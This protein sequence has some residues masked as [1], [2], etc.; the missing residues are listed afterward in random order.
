VRY[1]ALSVRNRSFV[2]LRSILDVFEIH[3]LQL[4][5]LRFT[6]S[7]RLHFQLLRSLPLIF[8]EILSVFSLDVERNCCTVASFFVLEESYTDSIFK[9]KLNVIP[10]YL[11]VCNFGGCLMPKFIFQISSSFGHHGVNLSLSFLHL[12]CS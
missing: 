1:V 10:N 2:P 5:L 9:T 4:G 6:V 11:V 8:K 7:C 12:L 3:R